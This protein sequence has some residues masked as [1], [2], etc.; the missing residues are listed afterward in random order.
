MRPVHIGSFVRIARIAVSMSQAELARRVG[1]S[2]AY[3]CQV[4]TGR[5][6]VS[7]T[8]ASRISAVLALQVG[9]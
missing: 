6:R 5:R 7:P 1:V 2:G 4:E 3:L 8:I 9:Q